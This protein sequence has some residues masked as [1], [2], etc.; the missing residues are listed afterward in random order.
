MP[1]EEVQIY[2]IEGINIIFYDSFFYSYP[3]EYKLDAVW[4][5]KIG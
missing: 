3:M 1:E 4:E 2:S 5:N